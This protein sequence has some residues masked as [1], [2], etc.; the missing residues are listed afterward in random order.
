[1]GNEGRNRRKGEEKKVRDVRWEN[2]ECRV[3]VKSWGDERVEVRGKERVER[4][5]D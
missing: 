5:R 2:I 1:M 4:K 3:N